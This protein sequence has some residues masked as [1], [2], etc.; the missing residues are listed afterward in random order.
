MNAQNCNLKLIDTESKCQKNMM[1]SLKKYIA[2]FGICAIILLANIENIIELA[3]Y[4]EEKKSTNST[5]PYDSK[6]DGGH[7]TYGESSTE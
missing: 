5:L 6:S 1:I 2:F 3:E 7:D 4:M